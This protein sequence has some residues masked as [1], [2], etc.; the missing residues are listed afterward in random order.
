M[1]QWGL[2][3]QPAS[4]ASRLSALVLADG[5]LFSIICYLQQQ[6]QTRLQ[7]RA[8]TTTRPTGAK[9]QTL[10]AI[11]QKAIAF[12][13]DPQSL[14]TQMKYLDIINS[15][16]NRIEQEFKAFAKAFKKNDLLPNLTSYLTSNS[17][18]NEFQLVDI[19]MSFYISELKNTD[20]D[21][22]DVSI[23]LF[24]IRNEENGITSYT[25]NIKYNDDGDLIFGKYIYV[26]SDITTSTGTFILNNSDYV[27][28]VRDIDSFEKDLSSAI[29]GIFATFK[30]SKNLALSKLI[31]LKNCT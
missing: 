4:A 12:R 30:T 5:I 8:D 24:Q 9:P 11:L 2:T 1:L 16:K 7:F 6:Q 3:E 29:D 20:E 15:C 22:I 10:S 17:F 23:G 28:S 19:T 25:S 27:I 21:G 14:K 26:T 31:E 18:I 13:S